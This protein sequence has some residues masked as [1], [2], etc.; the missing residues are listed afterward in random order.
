MP[1]DLRSIPSVMKAWV[2]TDTTGGIEKNLKFRSDVPLPPSAKSLRT[3]EVL[4]KTSAMSLNPVDYKIAELPILGRLIIKRPA[5]P[6]LDYAGKIVALGPDSGKFKQELKV[7]QSIIGRLGMPQQYGPLGEYL[8]ATRAGVVPAPSSGLSA[9]DAAGIGTAGLTAYQSITPYVKEGD[10]VFIN[11]GSGGVGLFGI[12]IAKLLGCHVTV[13]CSGANADLCKGVGADEVIDYRSSDVVEELKKTGRKYQLCVD[14]VGTN[15]IYWAMRSFTK[16]TAI[17]IQ[18]ALSPSFT[19]I[20][21][22]IQRMIIPGFLGGPGR[23]LTY[24]MARDDPEALAHLGQW[25][26]EGKIR[27]VT[28]QIFAYSDAPK[29]FALLKTHRARGKIVITTEV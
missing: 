9:E 17:H 19:D 12:Q 28:E 10:S 22:I 6:G 24:F 15:P 21:E 8:V 5:S 25:V 26:S 4:I 16:E 2:F 7:G 11:G 29:A 13:T 3:D 1:D 20:Y 23:K 18:V 27:V 14:N